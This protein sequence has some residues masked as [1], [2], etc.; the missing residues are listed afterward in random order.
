[1]MDLR[2]LSQ[3]LIFVYAV[4]MY[5]SAFPFVA[6]LEKSANA[7]AS[8]PPTLAAHAGKCAKRPDC[9]GRSCCIGLFVCFF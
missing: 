4:M 9:I 2:E 1:M 3:G 8:K 6:T 5:M 7:D